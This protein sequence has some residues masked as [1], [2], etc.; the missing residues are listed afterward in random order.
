MAKTKKAKAAAVPTGAPAAGNGF[1]MTGC[2]IYGVRW[3]GTQVAAVQT[4]AD[5]FLQNARGLSEMVALFKAQGVNGPLL[6]VG[7]LSRDEATVSRMGLAGTPRA[8]GR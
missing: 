1:T 5:A 3:D 7:D 8:D 2:T 4:I 6:H